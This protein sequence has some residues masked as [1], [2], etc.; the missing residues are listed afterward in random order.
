LKLFSKNIHDELDLSLANSLELLP[1]LTDN[2]TDDLGDVNKVWK[3]TL[4]VVNAKNRWFVLCKPYDIIF[5][6]FI[7]GS[8]NFVASLVVRACIDLMLPTTTS[9]IVENAQIAKF[10]CYPV[11][12][13]VVV[14]I[15]FV[16]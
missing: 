11:A 4:L 12:D 7:W 5:A 10:M 13:S 15:S 16:A 3:E 14:S 1:K 8:K 9:F 6:V 2:W